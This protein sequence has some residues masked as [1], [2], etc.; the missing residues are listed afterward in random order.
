LPLIP[1]G[2][3]RKSLPSVLSV[4]EVQRLLEA[5]TPGRDRLLLQVAYGCGLRL[6]ELT[7]LQVGDI[8]SSRMVLHVRQGKGGKDRLVPLSLRL[9]EEL[10]AYWRMHRVFRGKFLA[11]LR[12]LVDAGTLP[13]PGAAWFAT[14]YATD[15]VVYAKRPFGGPAQVLKYLARYTHRVAISNSRLL[16]LRDG[17]VTFRYKDYADEH[18]HKTMTLDAGEFL[19]RFVQHVLPSGFV[20]VRH[21]GLLANRHR[22][23]RLA[24]CRRLLRLAHVAATVPGAALPRIDPAQPR[25]CPQCGGTRLVYRD[26]PPEEATTSAVV[27]PDS[28]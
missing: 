22:A 18:R 13:H 25:C 26:L 2:K 3:R 17:R 10:R 28:S 24:L 1:F 14:L 21:Y 9:L 20:K 5:A 19:R 11:G 8:D 27:S 6:S 12:H 16:Q 7:H 23:E 15:W 4:A